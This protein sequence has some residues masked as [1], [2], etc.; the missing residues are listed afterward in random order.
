MINDQR[1]PF[2]LCDIC[3]FPKNNPIHECPRWSWVVEHSRGI[4]RVDNCDLF[5]PDNKTIDEKVKIWQ[6][7][8][9]EKEEVIKALKSF[10]EQ[11]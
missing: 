11:E 8:I 3:Q 5:K 9:K 7:K 1:R 4:I 6:D 2:D 10:K